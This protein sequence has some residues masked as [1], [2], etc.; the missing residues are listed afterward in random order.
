[1]AHDQTR[2][3][4][5]LA[6]HYPS[7]EARLEFVRALFNRAAADYDRVNQL[8][9]L[10]SGGWHRRDAL[11]RAGVGNGAVVLDVAIGTGLLAREVLRLVGEQ[12]CVTGLDLSENMLGRARQ[13][14]GIALIQGHA[15]AL[16]VADACMDFVTLG[17]ALRHVADLGVAFSE[18]RRVLRPGGTTLILEI[19]RPEG[20]RATA[21]ARLYLSRIVPALCRAMSADRAVGALMRYYWDTIEACVPPAVIL[22]ALNGAGFEA[23][24]CRTALGVF[25]AYTARRPT[26]E[27]VDFSRADGGRRCSGQY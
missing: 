13:A 16:P 21:L 17:Y 19:G 22:K 25:R 3:H 24:A 26:A 8:L 7:N 15:E 11:R 2:P 12:R 5:L 1:M 18:F 10:G 9:S 23:A 20:A 4:P 6:Q 14:L 27:V